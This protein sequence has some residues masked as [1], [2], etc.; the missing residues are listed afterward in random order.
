MRQRHATAIGR[1]PP[2]ERSDLR[3]RFDAV[4]ARLGILHGHEAD[5]PA[6]HGAILD[7]VLMLAPSRVD[8]GIERLS[9]VRAGQHGR[10]TSTSCAKFVHSALVLL[11][12]LGEIR[13]GSSPTERARQRRS[14]LLRCR[15]DGRL[16]GARGSTLGRRAAVPRGAAH[17]CGRARPRT[18]AGSAR[19]RRIVR[20][21]GAARARRSR[22]R[23]RRWPVLGSGRGAR[24]RLSRDH[25]RL[26]ATP[27]RA[28]R[29]RRERQR[30]AR[31]R[32]AARVVLGTAPGGRPGAGGS[33][34][35]CRG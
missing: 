12:I 21:R 7:V 11:P 28:A 19:R 10:E 24:Q 16:R 2:I 18:P 35:A 8:E 31:A 20:A 33:T 13:R 17:R 4:V 34:G 22:A 5:G 6:A 30:G 32:V 26:G 25:V 3:V 1:R 27:R 9:T 14:A 29:A 15:F 23:A